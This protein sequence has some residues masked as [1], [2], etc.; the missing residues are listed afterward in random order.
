MRWLLTKVVD[1]NLFCLYLANLNSLVTLAFF[2]RQS[3]V[4]GAFLEIQA[5]ICPVPYSKK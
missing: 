1:Y 5:V 4:S 2:W 3:L